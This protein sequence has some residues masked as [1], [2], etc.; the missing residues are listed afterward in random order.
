MS[1]FE[2]GVL[3]GFAIGIVAGVVLE[4]VLGVLVE[5]IELKIPEIEV[6]E[7]WRFDCHECGYMTDDDYSIDVISGL[8]EHCPQC[9]TPVDET[10]FTRHETRKATT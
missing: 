1:E 3:A 10:N 7:F 5:W 2:I 8:T 6:V 4:R 9:R